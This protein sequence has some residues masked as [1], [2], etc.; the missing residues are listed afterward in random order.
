MMGALIDG[1]KENNI[2]I[3]IFSSIAPAVNWLNIGIEINRV[4]SIIDNFKN[5]RV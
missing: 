4:E 3:E 2:P 5:T 1:L